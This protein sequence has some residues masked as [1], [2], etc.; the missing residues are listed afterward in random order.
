MNP[1]RIAVIG[2]ADDAPELLE[3][4][5]DRLLQDDT[6][7]QIVYLGADDALDRAMATRTRSM[8]SQEAFLERSAKLA[9]D[10]DPDA[11]DALLQERHAAQRLATVRRLP[12]T[13]ALAVEM[14]EKWILVMVHD[15]GV[16][17]EDD[18]ANAHVILYGGSKKPYF[19]RFGPRCFFTPGPL[20]G[21]NIGCLELSEGGE[22]SIQL[23]DAGGEVVK[24]ES[25]QGAATKFSVTT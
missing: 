25:L 13:P 9:C 4:T 10:G 1:S 18:I 12:P 22:L 3:Q 24:T 14:L 7:R 16:L 11:I 15:K 2:A 6:L 20:T 17:E 19:K 21:G 8:L 23:I 5:L